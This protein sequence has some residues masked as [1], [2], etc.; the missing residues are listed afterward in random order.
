MR[1]FTDS[2]GGEWTLDLT[3]A[4]AKPLT[5]WLKDY[6]PPVDFFRAVDFMTAA[7]SII[8]AIDC[9]S[10]LCAEQRQARGMSDRDFGQAFR[11]EAA[12]KAQRALIEEY[13]DFFPDPA[14]SG[15]LKNCL[16]RLEDSSRREGE[17]VKRAMDQVAEDYNRRVTLIEKS[18]STTLNTS[19]DSPD[20]ETSQTINN[21]HSGN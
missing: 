14:T 16:Q 3:I 21:T 4:T 8:F 7:T 1:N 18:L 5:I 11:G 20:L 15:T 17:I 10:F 6:D 19:Q 2:T 9:L 13:V 12:Y